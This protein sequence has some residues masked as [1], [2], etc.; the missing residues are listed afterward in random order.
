MKL[1]LISNILVPLFGAFL[2]L[3]VGRKSEST[4]S[5]LIKIVSF[6]FG[7][8]V[9]L[10]LLV[11]VYR[12]AEVFS[13]RGNHVY[14][15]G[16]YEFPFALHFDLLSAVFLCVST[17]MSLLILHYSRYYMHRESGY[18][19]F[20]A[21]IMLFMG[22]LTFLFEAGTLDLLFAGWEVVGISSFLLIAFYKTRATSCKN[23]YLTYCVY[24][25]C[26]VGLLLSACL[27]HFLWNDGQ[28]FSQMSLS[29]AFI[30]EHSLPLTL[31]GAF[32]L[33]AACGK[34]AQF[35]FSFWLSRA[36]EG[37]TP[38]SA[39]FYGAISVHLGVF[40]LIRMYPF[41][42]SIES[43]VW[44]VAGIG[45]L[46]A[47]LGTI[48]ARSQSSIKGRIAYDSL[49][50]VG[51]MF[52]ELALGFP[53]MALLHFIANSGLRCSQLLLSPSVVVAT[54][55]KQSSRGIE[56]NRPVRWLGFK[57]SQRLRA[58]LYVLSLKEGYLYAALQELAQVP[59]HIFGRFLKVL[60]FNWTR[61]G[62]LFFGFVA[63]S[64]LGSETL[65]DYYVWLAVVGACV[66]L[67][68]ALSALYENADA[69]RAWNATGF[70]L[71]C[72]TGS[73]LLTAH[74]CE[75]D[76]LLF[77]AGVGPAWI[78][79]A[80]ILRHLKSKNDQTLMLSNYLGMQD[81]HPVLAFVFFICF[82]E[83]VGFPIGPVFIAED[84]YLHH[85]TDHGV[86]LVGVFVVAFVVNGVSLAR[87]FSRVFFGTRKLAAS[88]RGATVPRA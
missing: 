16:N 53:K 7:V 28:Q 78:V 45:L 33:L 17:Y 18:S 60:S 8:S 56:N 82:L 1:L 58:S 87:V 35:P 67:L 47:I 81:E 55:K 27:V 37:P 43:I 75:K 19:R 73:L 52:V 69:L 88:I 36:M 15:N 70:S 5:S 68:S 44:C 26:D 12:G 10:T 29:P 66:A 49:A 34:S 24:R 20:F 32:I 54:L 84:A 21:I 11:W 48:S 22:G 3:I 59:K 39:I 14:Q 51:L 83:V 77:W 38:S 79:G 13:W 40:I 25:V 46:S 9:A 42:H 50:Q 74:N 85:L 62:I 57:I 63:F 65:A 61:L 86:W 6:V 71:A 76:C 31:L 4:A 64:Y 72:L 2:M 80:L 30:Q 23:A 41:W